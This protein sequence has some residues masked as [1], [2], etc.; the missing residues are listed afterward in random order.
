[1]GEND[2]TEIV[3]DVDNSTTVKWGTKTYQAVVSVR[4]DTEEL[5][6]GGR[7]QDYTLEAVLPYSSFTSGIPAIGDIF[8]IG[9]VDYRVVEIEEHGIGGGISFTL[10]NDER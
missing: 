4:R 2:L 5:D 3:A 7:M 9:A 6:L 1:M 8:R 10:A